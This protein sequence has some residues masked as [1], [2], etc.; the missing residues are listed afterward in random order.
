MFS[1]SK[2]SELIVTELLS[3]INMPNFSVIYVGREFLARLARSQVRF[4]SLASRTRDKFRIWLLLDLM[5]LG[6]RILGAESDLHRAYVRWASSRLSGIVLS[7]NGVKFVM[8]DFEALAIISED[9][10]PFMRYWFLPKMGQIVLDV[11][12]HVGAYT[13]RAAKMVG[14]RGRVIALEPTPA[15][16]RMLLQNV[17]LNNADNVT[18]VNVAAWNQASELKLYHAYHPGLYSVKTDRDQG[19]DIV[20]AKP[21][22]EILRTLGFNHVDWVKIDTEG[23]EREVLEGMLEMLP[24]CPN[25]IAEVNSANRAWLMDFVKQYDYGLVCISPTESNVTYFVLTRLMVLTPSH[26]TKNS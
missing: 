16:Y 22:A 4:L 1:S 11:G 15:T 10:E 24:S 3:P 9:F 25:I 18:V 20:K 17:Q 12:A 7:S 8:P 5:R 2:T 13:L 14:D 26:P 21:I 6:P 19:Y 23:A